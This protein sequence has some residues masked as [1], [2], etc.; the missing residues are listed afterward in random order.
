MNILII[1]HSIQIIGF[2]ILIFPAF[3]KKRIR[4]PWAKLVFVLVSIIGVAK[5]FVQLG[6]DFSW[7]T[8]SHGAGYLLNDYVSMTGGLLVGFLFA[9][10][11]SGQLN[12]KKQPS[13]TAP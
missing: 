9:L 12:G 13:I 3:D 11:F 5:A 6:I 2:A 4:A 1:F 7:F 8:V 10:I